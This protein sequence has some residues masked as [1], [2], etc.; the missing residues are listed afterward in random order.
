MKV[1]YNKGDVRL[2]ERIFYSFMG[3]LLIFYSFFMALSIQLLNNIIIKMSTLSNPWA[4][5]MILLPLFLMGITIL[6][7]KMLW[8]IILKGDD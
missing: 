5:L 1:T 4:G 7:I 8:I 2:A 6:I 3:G